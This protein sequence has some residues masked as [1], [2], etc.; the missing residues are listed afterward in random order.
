MSCLT[1]R[2]NS[3]THKHLLSLPPSLS[4]LSVSLPLPPS[5]LSPLSPFSLL[6]PLSPLLSLNSSSLKLRVHLTGADQALRTRCTWGFPG[7]AICFGTSVPPFCS[8]LHPD[9]W[10]STCSQE[11]PQAQLPA[12]RRILQLLSALVPCPALGLL[13]VEVEVQPLWAL[14]WQR[15]DATLPCGEQRTESVHSDDFALLPASLVQAI[16]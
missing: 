3:L 6:S 8:L 12:A 13:S 7:F 16:L 11:R 4:P 10:W 5:P 2:C 15:R 1:P 9:A 14:S